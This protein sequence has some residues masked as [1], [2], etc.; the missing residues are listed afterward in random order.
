MKKFFMVIMLFSA[1]M[2]FAFSCSKESTQ[3]GD[4]VKPAEVQK[5]KEKED[6]VYKVEVGTSVFTGPQDAP[7]TIINFSDFQCPFSKRSVDLVEK[8]MKEYDGKI[9][10]V[11]KH[12]PLGFHKLAKPAALASIAAHKQGKFWQY[13]SKLFEDIKKIDEENIVKWASDLGL[14]MEKFNEDRNSEE[15]GRILQNDIELGTQFGVRGT[16]TLFINGRRIVGANNVKIRE[17]LASRIAEG[18]KIKAKGVKDVYGRIVENG[19]TK[20]VPPKRDP[21]KVPTDVFKVEIPEHS[22]VW[23]GKDAVI[24]MVLFDDF[25]CPFCSRLH[26]TYEQIKKEYG[27]NI[28]I[29]FINLPLRFHKKAVPAAIAAMAAHKQDKFWEMYDRLF[30]KQKEWKKAGDLNDWLEKEAESIGLDMEKF[31]NDFE[32]K[33]IRN[34]IEKDKAIAESMGIRGTPATFINGRFVNGALPFETFKSVIDEEL[35]KVEPLK[36]K[37]LT[38]D[39]L[40][41]EIIKDG[42]T[43]VSKSAG[44]DK[45]GKD[46]DKIYEIKLSGNEPVK[47]NKDA[48]ITIVEFSEF[49]CPFCRKGAYAVEEVIEDYK[50]KVKL[51]FKHMPLA[52]HKEAKPAA[53]FTIAV[54]ITY[55]DEKFFQTAK[56]LFEKQSEW[57]KD[58]LKAFEKYAKELGMDWNKVKSAMESPE[59]DKIL[60][61]DMAEA[62]RHGIRGVPA[63]F[64]NGKMVSGAKK[65]E[66]FKAVIDNLLKQGKK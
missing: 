12:F 66:Y 53:F 6:A 24:T 38:G 64:I 4:A 62:V 33:Q 2:L 29:A 14:D 61:E 30:E 22:P 50:D 18:E 10:Y 17:M 51:V 37:G 27:D 43:R 39:D 7:V 49:Q 28:R 11:F 35:K 58:H 25:E 40:Y 56:K 15:A 3:K 41:K 26:K 36:A 21:G 13:Y 52:F 46:P 55:G 9:R 19:L 8:L 16:P 45:K 47:G 20:Y 1:V 32:S 54:K 44:R 23:S 31:K 65:K 57:K 42:L 59:A 63:F 60:K 5:T 34:I 48:E